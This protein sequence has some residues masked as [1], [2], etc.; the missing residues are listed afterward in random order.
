MTGQINY[1]H[2]AL[3]KYLVE[4]AEHPSIK[5]IVE[6]GAWN[7]LGTTRCI[8]HG[9]EKANKKE[10]KFISLECNPEQYINAVNN[11]CKKINK[12]FNLVYGKIIDESV[13]TSWFDENEL[14]QEQHDWLKQ[15]VEWLAKVPNVLDI[16]PEVIDFLVLDGGEFT[17]YLEWS[18][19]KERVNYVALDDSTTLKCKKIR[20]EIIDSNKFKILVD[21]PNG[22]R[23]GCFIA[24]RL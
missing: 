5:V 4:I 12:N 13:I 17:T 1:E 18:V 23:Y 14:T 22:S 8:L 19:L 3:G 2:D 16:I 24:K 11:N 7:G 21:D 6:I 9:L 15:D 20:Q 10:Y